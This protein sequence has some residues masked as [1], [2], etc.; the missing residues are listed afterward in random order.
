MLSGKKIIVGVTGSIAAYKAALLV[1]LLVKD[2]AE[3]QVVMTEAAKRFV[4]ELTFSNLS[5]KPVFSGLWDGTWS[6]HV[7]LGLWGDIMLV[8]PASANTLAKMA[9]GTCD[10]ALTAVYLSAKCPVMVAPAMDADMYVHPSTT[11][12][13]AQLTQDGVDVLPSDTGFLA[14]GLHGPGRMAE[15]EAILARVQAHFAA[16]GPLAGKKV[17]ISAGPTREHLDPVRFISNGSTGTM[18]YALARAAADLG[19]TTTVVSGPVT[20][21]GPHPFDVV[22][23]TSTADMY[24]AMTERAP[25]H[26]IIIMSAAVGDY[27]PSDFSD[28]KIKKGD[29]DLVVSFKRTQDIL[30]AMG[31]AKKSGQILVGFALETNNEEANA[32]GKLQKKNLDYIVLNS[33]RDKGAGFG[34]STN[35]ISLIDQSGHI[36]RY[37]LKSKAEVA[38]D[39]LGRLVK[40]LG[41]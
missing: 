16:Q 29:G 30:K 31:S 24:A 9:N 34:R 5:Q 36:E 22:D 15:P 3:V 25:P 19:A 40:D 10:N 41:I 13:L 7:H 20:Q 12:N 35:K 8:A 32:R 38:R 18:G 6:E 23:V 33:L 28:Q 39:I 14:S 2:G 17:L 11:R 21:P 4:T 26:D 37:P 27:T 1:R